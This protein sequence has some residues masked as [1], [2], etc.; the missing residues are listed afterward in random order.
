MIDPKHIESLEALIDYCYDEVPYFGTH[1]ALFET[2]TDTR[3]LGQ[4]ACEALE[5]LRKL[6]ESP[7]VQLALEGGVVQG[8]SQALSRKSQSVILSKL[9]ESASAKKFPYGITVEVSCT[10]T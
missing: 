4:R 8:A 7:L 10:P 3:S 2:D 1:G 9:G 5:A 6:P